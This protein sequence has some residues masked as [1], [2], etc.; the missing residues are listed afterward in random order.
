MPSPSRA[1]PAARA[2]APKGGGGA[3]VGFAELVRGWNGADTYP[4]ESLE[5]LRQVVQAIDDHQPLPANA[6]RL[7]RHAFAGYLAGDESDITKAMG[8]R[9][10]RGRR[11]PARK[12]QQQ[13][14]NDLLRRVFA[15]TTAAGELERARQLLKVVHSPSPADAIGETEVTAD[16]ERLRRDFAGCIPVSPEQILRVVK[17][18]R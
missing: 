2:I 12:K 1:T 10:A 13:E 3:S 16:V 11:N 15:G 5:A 14:R 8:L 17:A 4:I 6:A 9:P 7:V 18:P